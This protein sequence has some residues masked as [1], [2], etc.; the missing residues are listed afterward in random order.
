MDAKA[1]VKR[2]GEVKREEMKARLAD[3]DED[4]DV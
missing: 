2:A 1:R 4:D 3:Y